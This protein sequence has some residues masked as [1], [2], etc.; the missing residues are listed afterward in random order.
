MSQTI[1]VT[2]VTGVLG[3]PVAQ[4]LKDAGFQVRAMSR[5]VDKIRQ[6]YGDTFEV[7]AA[8]VMAPKS[9]DAAM[10]G[11]WGVH[12]SIASEEECQAA[13]NIVAAAL[14]HGVERISYTSGATVCPDNGWFPMVR[15]KLGAEKAIH[16]STIPFGVFCP[17]WFM[18]MLPRFV[19]NGRAVLLGRQTGPLY[20]VSADDYGRMVAAFY[21]LEEAPNKRFFIYGPEG[22]SMAEALQ[23]YC[24]TFHP[25]IEKP[26]QMPLWLAKLIARLTRNDG[27][28][29]AADLMAYFQKAVEPGSP[30]EANHLLGAPLTTLDQWIVARKAGA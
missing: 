4:Q 8:D 17:T 24:Q 27:L 20:W 1:L 5:S 29:Y 28:K 19:Q 26:G 23:R 7:V 18:D 16:D 2:G 22:I 21:Q 13:E 14:K 12:I 6:R 30:T 11:C 25:Q 10:E 15:E 3:G 9:L